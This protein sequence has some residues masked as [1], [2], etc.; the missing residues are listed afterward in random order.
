MAY[1]R[2]A[3]LASMEPNL[4]HNLAPRATA[5]RKAMTN[6][7]PASPLKKQSDY[8]V[9]APLAS[10]PARKPISSRAAPVTPRVRK[11]RK[12]YLCATPPAVLHDLKGLREYDRGRQLG[13]GGFARCFLVQNKDGSL[14]AAKTVSKSSLQSTKMKGK[15]GFRGGCG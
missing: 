13:E 2:P 4:H 5:H 11:E 12:K 14:F 15:V 8:E 6:R 10:K 1:R 9:V 3:P 7:L